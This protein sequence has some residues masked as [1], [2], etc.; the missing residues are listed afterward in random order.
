MLYRKIL[1]DRE[2]SGLNTGYCMAFNIYLFYVADNRSSHVPEN[3]AKCFIKINSFIH[4]I[5]IKIIKGH[6]SPHF[7]R[8]KLRNK[9]AT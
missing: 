5:F 4:L 1:R 8:K 3:C 2:R 7:T 6:S 9:E